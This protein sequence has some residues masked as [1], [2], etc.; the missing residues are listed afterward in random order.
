MNKAANVGAGI[1]NS[2]G[3]A[4]SFANDL[5]DDAKWFAWE[6]AVK[7][8]AWLGR[9]LANTIDIA[10]DGAALLTD[11]ISWGVATMT[12]HPEDATN[13]SGKEWI[14]DKVNKHV[15]G[16]FDQIEDA[17]KSKVGKTTVGKFISDGVG[18]AWELLSPGWPTAVAWKLGKWFMIAKEYIPFIK[19]S[20]QAIAELKALMEW[21][22]KIG[23]KVDQSEVNAILSK[24]APEV[25]TMVTK[26]LTKGDAALAAKSTIKLLDDPKKIDL[27]EKIAASSPEEIASKWPKIS[28]LIKTGKLA[29]KLWVAETIRRLEQPEIDAIDEELNA[30]EAPKEPTK[31]TP[32]DGITF[33]DMPTSKDFNPSE[34][35]K[36][37]KVEDTQTVSDKKKE[38]ELLKEKNAG[39]LNASSSVVDLMKMLWANSTMEARKM[40]FEGLTSKPYEG[41]AE[42]NIQL[43]A[44][45]EE[46]FAN[47][48]LSDKIKSFKR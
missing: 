20:P 16:G 14:I 34:W 7:W 44:L 8:A 42:Q 1:V 17:T 37:N 29:G 36:F 18:I 30:Q 11:A 45:V 12:G 5:M 31:E 38:L 10:G 39:T 26:A 24:Y 41:T 13:Y 2:I 40:L 6:L 28:A 43:K 32:N 4:I 27:L 22:A 35:S 9:G 33:P 23:K 21:A 46:M 19:K 48:T 3:G 15:Q 47:G 25:K